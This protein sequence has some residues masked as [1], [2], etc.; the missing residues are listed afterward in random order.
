VLKRVLLALCL[1]ALIGTAVAQNE[2]A[3]PI[4]NK[5]PRFIIFAGYTYQY[6]RFLTGDRS[7]L[8]G[9]EASLEGLHLRPHL[10]FVADGSAHYGWNQFLSPAS[11]SRSSARPT[12][13]F[14]RQGIRFIDGPQYRFHGPNASNPSCTR[15]AV[16]RA[17]MT[18]PD[19]SR[20]VG[21]GK[22]Q[23]AGR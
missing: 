8:H 12:R 6:T 2:P 16:T 17:T 5:P 3:E 11:L 18:T 9:Y 22:W 1:A 13:Q 10:S 15:S 21:R 23:R 19:S 7:N 20:V 4:S 14:A